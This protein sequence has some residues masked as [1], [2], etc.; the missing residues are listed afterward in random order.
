VRSIA[1]CPWNS[2]R[3]YASGSTVLAD[4][5]LVLDMFSESKK[6]A[7]RQFIEFH[8][9]PDDVD[10]SLPDRRRRT[11]EQMRAEMC[12]VIGEIEPSAVTG[13]DR[14]ER[15]SLL[16]MLRKSGFSIRQIER[17]TEIS[18]GVIARV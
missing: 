10:R 8:S 16:T 14:Q 17:V 5:G 11:R 2:Y 13:L 7:V 4:T 9:I 12:E 1:D 3:D 18:R 15:N 6:E